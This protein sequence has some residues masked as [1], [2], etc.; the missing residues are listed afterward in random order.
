MIQ[1]V[2]AIVGRVGRDSLSNVVGQPTD[3]TITRSF[4][5]FSFRPSQKKEN[6]GCNKTDQNTI[7]RII[8]LEEI[9][10][11]KTNLSTYI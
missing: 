6:D 7:G 4:E 11:K 9:I 3:R 10:I 2:N 8:K 1:K 5:R